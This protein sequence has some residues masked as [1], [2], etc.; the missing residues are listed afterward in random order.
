MCQNEESF[1]V[2]L[3]TCGD[4]FIQAVWSYMQNSNFDAKNSRK[5]YQTIGCS[6]EGC[7]PGWWWLL[8]SNS[9]TIWR[10][11]FLLADTQICFAV[12]ESKSCFILPTLSSTSSKFMDE[13]Q[14]GVLSMWG[15]QIQ[16][17]GGMQT[18]DGWVQQIGDMW[19][20]IVRIGDIRWI[21]RGAMSRS[22]SVHKCCTKAPTKFPAGFRITLK[23]AHIHQ[24]HLPHYNQ[25]NT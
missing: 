8:L 16:G 20:R 17:I 19:V 12:L 10:G 1:K 24:T 6:F 2:Q 9:C 7:Q 4:I 22:F 21:A 3:G 11:L 5:I 23:C 25:T 15:A 18:W 13:G 14:M